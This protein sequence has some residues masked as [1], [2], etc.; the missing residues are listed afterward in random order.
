MKAK[1]VLSQRSADRGFSI[2]ELVIAMAITLS[3]MAAATTLLATSL[4]TRG[5]ENLRSEALASTQRALNIMSRE[6]GNSGYGLADNGIV[7]GDSGASSIRVRANL[8]NNSS[9]GGTDEDIRYVFQI[10]NG[11]AGSIVRYDNSGGGNVVLATNIS[12]LLLT[13]FDVNG[14]AIANSVNYDKAERL[15][16]EVRVDLPAGLEQPATTVKLVS[17]VALRNAPNTLDSF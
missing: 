4:R 3:I 17:D 7:L 11:V 5:R 12:A 15:T 14:N 9:L 10:P 13:Y 1:Q 16:I 6:I 8:D 2:I